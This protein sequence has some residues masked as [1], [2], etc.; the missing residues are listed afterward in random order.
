MADCQTEKANVPRAAWRTWR[1]ACLIPWTTFSEE[2]HCFV[3][4]GAFRSEEKSA[5]VELTAE[6]GNFSGLPGVL[7]W[8]FSN[9]F[10]L[11]PLQVTSI[12]SHSF[13][14]FENATF[15]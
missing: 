9:F 11:R 2:R 7:G 3:A 5:W 8:R 10:G 6:V 13:Q 4:A 15:F 12:D 1:A 14:Y